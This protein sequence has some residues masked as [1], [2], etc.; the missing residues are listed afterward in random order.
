M[1]FPQRG[2]HKKRRPS[3]DPGTKV[4]VPKKN[5]NTLTDPLCSLWKLG[6]SPLPKLTETGRLYQVYC[7]FL[8]TRLVYFK[9]CV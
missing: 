4:F 3:Y 9:E 6:V 1:W 7:A 8:W 2:P 5:V